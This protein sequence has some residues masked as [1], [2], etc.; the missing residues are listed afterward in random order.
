MAR[1][2]ITVELSEAEL[3]QLRQYIH[4][5][6]EGE[7][8]GWYYGNKAQFEKRHAHLIAVFTEALGKFIPKSMMM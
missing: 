3:D 1:K 8:R 2:K 5:L 6:D 4:S 7:S